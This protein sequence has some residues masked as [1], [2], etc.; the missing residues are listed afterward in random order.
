MNFWT[1]GLWA[2]AVP[3][4]GAAVLWVLLILT[5]AGLTALAFYA[6][7]LRRR[8][9]DL[10]DVRE[11]IE[12]NK[13]QYLI[14]SEKLGV[15]SN[16]TQ[17]SFLAH[18]SHQLRTPLNI[19]INY[20]ELL[21]ELTRQEGREDN[22][23]E[24]R[25]I[26]GAG[27]ELQDKINN[28]LELSK[29]Q[30]GSLSIATDILPT[31]AL[32]QDITA[33]L[34]MELETS[35]NRLVLE[36]GKAPEKLEVDSQRLHQILRHLLQNAFKFTKGGVVTL[37]I[38]KERNPWTL[39]RIS[40]TGPG[41]DPHILSN[42]F[43][44][45][46]GDED[47]NNI[48]TGLGLAISRSLCQA[49]GGDITVES[50]PGVGSTFSVR[51]PATYISG[52]ADVAAEDQVRVLIINDDT[53]SRAPMSNFLNSHGYAVHV[54]ED[55][56]EALR[57]ARSVKPHVIVLDALMPGLV[58]RAVM[59][60]LRGE[61]S[62][63][64]IPMIMT[65]MMDELTSTFKLGVIGYL[66]KPVRE[67]RFQ[68]MLQRYLPV[69][70]DA[71]ILVAEDDA[72]SRKI[73]CKRITRAGWSVALAADGAE[74]LEKVRLQPPALIFLDLMMPGMD[75]FDLLSELRKEEAWKNIPV[76]FVSAARINEES[77]L[78][79]P[80]DFVHVSNDGNYSDHLFLERLRQ[81]IV[82]YMNQS[83]ED[84]VS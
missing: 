24:I 50:K 76:I 61:D 16:R 6:G 52:G 55:R 17:T 46:I 2:S 47:G 14:R 62:L 10:Q 12:Q 3:T 42:L 64:R 68:Q 21:E 30:A 69:H 5:A 37:T 9:H 35:G 63:A 54:A 83:L 33:G 26:L 51:L 56:E 45:F 78:H 27:R 75:G 79:P 71:P 73:M 81:Q 57:L 41:I 20:S 1:S 49:M 84:K 25:K 60:D 77:R 74:A 15:Q 82:L 36:T 13:I 18:I 4:P 34:K 58:S 11:E 67:H 59:E 23:P 39:F 7:Y 72:I 44:S 32:V 8:L 40:D 38:E 29:I 70:T 53:E 66:K 43:A 31:R 28:V 80:G 65:S 19:V 22:L 48:G